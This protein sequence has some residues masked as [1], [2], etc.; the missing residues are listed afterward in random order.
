MKVK[1]LIK[2]LSNDEDEDVS[3]YLRESNK[4]F[5]VLS[6]GSGVIE[7]KPEE[8]NWDIPLQKG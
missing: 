7:I 4:Y 2:K 1:E 8:M 5:E 3:I 6:V